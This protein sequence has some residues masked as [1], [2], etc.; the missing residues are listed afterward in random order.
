MFAK[1]GPLGAVRRRRANMNAQLA[2]LNKPIKPKA[3]PKA[4]K[5]KTK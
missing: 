3:K 5:K 1:N 2:E 4:K